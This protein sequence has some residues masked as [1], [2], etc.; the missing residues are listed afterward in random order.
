MPRRIFY[1]ESKSTEWNDIIIIIGDARQ[2]QTAS[3]QFSLAAQSGFF[4]S[5]AVKRLKKIKLNK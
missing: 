4:P 3:S 2:P 1:V 5:L